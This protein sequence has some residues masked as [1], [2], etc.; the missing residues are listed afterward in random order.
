MPSGCDSADSEKKKKN[1]QKESTRLVPSQNQIHSVKTNPN[2]LSLFLDQ[3][4]KFSL[5][6]MA[7]TLQ[8]HSSKNQTCGYGPLWDFLFLCVT[9][10]GLPIPSE[11]LPFQGLMLYMFLVQS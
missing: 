10:E 11:C 6:W 1:Y 2:D 5:R 8:G 3:H 4:T 9:S 7:D